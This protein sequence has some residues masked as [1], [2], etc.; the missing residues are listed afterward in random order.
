MGPQSSRC[1]AAGIRIAHVPTGPTGLALGLSQQVYGI[2]TEF[3]PWHLDRKA[4]KRRVTLG[5]NTC[6]HPQSTHSHTSHIKLH[7]S[8]MRRSYLVPMWVDSCRW[9]CGWDMS[10]QL[11]AMHSSC[12]AEWCLGQV[13]SCLDSA[14]VRWHIYHS[15]QQ[16]MSPPGAR[17]CFPDPKTPHTRTCHS[18]QQARA[19][20][21]QPA[22]LTASEPRGSAADAHLHCWPQPDT[23]SRSQCT[24]SRAVGLCSGASWVQA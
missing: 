12:T 16:Q 15:V 9:N 13:C 6:S 2:W 5:T 14:Q 21:R 3:L 11:G 20:C 19:A 4:H 24:T 7:P 18:L 1:C 22:R 17:H 8:A 23:S 10:R